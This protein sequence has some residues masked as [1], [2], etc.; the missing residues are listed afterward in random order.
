MRPGIRGLALETAYTYMDPQDLDLDEV[1]AY[2]PRHI[3]QGTLLY[4]LGPVE[5][6]ADYRYISRL[7]VVKLYPSDDRVAQKTLD[8]HLTWN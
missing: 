7:E 5:I 6:S 4:G 3:A 2:R 1:L 8:L